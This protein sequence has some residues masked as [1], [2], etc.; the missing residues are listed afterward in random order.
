MRECSPRICAILDQRGIEPTAQA[1]DG[2]SSNLPQ[3]V[4]CLVH[5]STSLGE[6]GALIETCN[7]LGHLL[8]CHDRVYNGAILDDPSLAVE[9]WL[10]TLVPA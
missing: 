5:Y 6:P 2:A 10:D 3:D 7:R 1:W 8:F 9:Q 4:R